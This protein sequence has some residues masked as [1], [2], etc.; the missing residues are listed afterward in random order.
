ME[1]YGRLWV[2][3]GSAS[4]TGNIEAN[5][6]RFTLLVANVRLDPAFESRKVKEKH[7]YMSRQNTKLL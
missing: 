5:S 1:W 2:T 4:I 6:A 7:R 3:T